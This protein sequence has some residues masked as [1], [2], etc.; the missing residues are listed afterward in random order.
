MGVDRI[1][2][3]VPN[4]QIASLVKTKSPPDQLDISSV[5]FTIR[6]QDDENMV[7]FG[8]QTQSSKTAPPYWG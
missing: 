5:D 1:T 8:T 2:Q 7:T 6:E 3:T 4:P